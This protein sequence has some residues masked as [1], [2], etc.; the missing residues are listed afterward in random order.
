MGHSKT[1][2]NYQ[3][4]ARK[5]DRLTNLRQSWLAIPSQKQKRSNPNQKPMQVASHLLLP[6]LTQTHPHP[7]TLDFK[8]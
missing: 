6:Q 4:L 8:Q 5:I 3:T 7:E 2:F 1:Q